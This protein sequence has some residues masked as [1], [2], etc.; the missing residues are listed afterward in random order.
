MWPY[1][2]FIDIY[3]LHTTSVNR[4]PLITRLQ[5]NFLIIFFFLPF[6]FFFLNRVSCVFTSI[7]YLNEFEDAK[8]FETE[9]L[10]YFNNVQ[11]ILSCGKK[12]KNN[13][14]SSSSEY[15]NCVLNIKIHQKYK[16]DLLTFTLKD[17]ENEFNFKE[18]IEVGAFNFCNSFK[19]SSS[20][21]SESA[22]INAQVIGGEE[23][24]FNANVDADA[25]VDVDINFD[26]KYYN[27]SKLPTAN[28]KPKVYNQKFLMKP[29]V[30]GVICLILILI[31]YLSYLLVSK[32]KK[33]NEDL[34]QPSP[35][36]SQSTQ[37]L[38]QYHQQPFRQQISYNYSPYNN[39]NNQNLNFTEAPPPSYEEVLNRPFHSF[40]GD[41]IPYQHDKNY[42][43]NRNY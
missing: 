13:N 4:T 16:N 31:C 10:K 12:Y 33:S 27:N 3:I 26:K 20:S 42:D 39:A 6:L 41:K 14:L 28:V 37:N 24:N 40:S 7:C 34:P 19:N 2:Q 18:A 36:Q 25:D 30:I 17:F 43:N 11:S 5:M 23:F 35:L 21:L 38:L 1:G 22:M 9:T 29:L 32:N 15:K 8:N